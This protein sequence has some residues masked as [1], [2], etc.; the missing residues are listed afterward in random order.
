MHTQA[1]LFTPCRHHHRRLCSQSTRWCVAHG[2][3]LGLEQ[4]Q[5]ARE[6]GEGSRCRS[7]TFR[8]VAT[9]CPWCGQGANVFASSWAPNGYK[10]VGK[11]KRVCVPI[12]REPGRERASTYGTY[13][14]TSQ[15]QATSASW[16]HESKEV[17][18]LAVAPWEASR[19]LRFR[20]G[21]MTRKR[22]TPNQRLR[23][24]ARDGKSA[25]GSSASTMARGRCSRPTPQAAAVGAWASYKASL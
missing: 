10:A 2:T 16:R 25:L 22:T 20:T 9:A 3:Q 12:R 8:L 13:A 1:G 14:G 19:S 24:C 5:E 15:S 18:S 6:V 21:E 4:L 17:A 11:R 7:T 23:R